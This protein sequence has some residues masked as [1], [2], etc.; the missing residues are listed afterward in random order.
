M[1]RKKLAIS[2][3]ILLGLSLFAPLSSVFAAGGLTL[4]T[5]YTG[6]SVTPGETLTYDVTVINDNS[7][8]QNVSF[9]VN[10]LPEGWDSA[11]TA[12]GN[13][14]SQ[15]SIRGNNEQE[16]SLEVTVPLEV[17][18]DDYS[19]ELVADG[20]GDAYAELP[21]VTK[22]TEEGTFNSEFSS[23]QPNMEGHADATFSYSATLRNRTADEQTYAL[24]AGVGEGWGV[25]FQADGNNVTSVTL[26]PN[27]SKD[28]TVEVTPP[29]DVKADTYE[30]PISAA[31]SSTS[32]ELTLEA[33]ITGSYEIAVSTPDGNLSADVTAGN[34]R[35]IDLVVE[36]TGTA[37]LNDISISASTP[38]NWESEFDESSIATLEA[39]ES[40]TVKAT[41]TA[42]DD[43]IAGDYVTTFTAETSEASS[44]ADFRV[45]VETSTL[46]GIIS[47]LIIL[48]VVGGL[49]F[50]IRK[51]GRR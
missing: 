25:Q 2:L 36:N 35:T 16:I 37:A 28:I 49:Y 18:K 44:D 19:F 50:I 17:E 15:L 33:V 27:G 3:T 30:I 7:S 11:I 1:L 26:E 45:S 14:I 34:D 31:N 51:Y 22:V 21:F 13:D 6:L 4:Y 43:A 8:I 38:P 24:S 46:W 42:P 48:A 5:P 10:G 20:E 23:D 47:V 39:G 32:S 12:G 40:K 9:D 41:F 29:T